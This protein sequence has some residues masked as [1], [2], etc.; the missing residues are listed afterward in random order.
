MSEGVQP[1][2]DWDYVVDRV[3]PR[4]G[5]WTGKPTFERAVCFVQ[6]FDLALGSEM[7]TRLQAW[8]EA[9]Y[10]KSNIGW[11]WLLIRLTLGTPR[12]VL[13]GRDLGGLTDEEDADACALLQ[14]ALQELVRPSP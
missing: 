8:A 14:Q 1:R 9:R 12:D 2:P 6:G 13:E 5:M 3:L 7:N 11:P 10:G 4:L